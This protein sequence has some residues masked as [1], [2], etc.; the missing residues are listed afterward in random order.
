VVRGPA[1]VERMGDNVVIP[2]G[3]QAAVDRYLNL[4]LSGAAEVVPGGKAAAGRLEV[5]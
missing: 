5:G 4:R 3:Y 2:P 1:I